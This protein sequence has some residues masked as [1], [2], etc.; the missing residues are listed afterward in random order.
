MSILEKILI[1]GLIVAILIATYYVFFSIKKKKKEKSDSKEKDKKIKKSK[2]SKDEIKESPLVE[3][4]VEKVFKS[5][6]DKEEEKPT[7][8][9]SQEQEMVLEKQPEKKAEPFKII[10]KKSEVKI[11]KKAIKADSRNPSITKVF[12]KNGKKLELDENELEKKDEFSPD[13]LSQIESM[14]NDGVMSG[15][16]G[17]NPER[18]GYREPHIKERN[19]GGEYKIEAPIGSPNRA[20]IIRDRTNF[21]SH[22]NISEDGNLSGVVGT[23][24]AKIIDRAERQSEEIDKK[25]DDMIRNIRM[26]LLNERREVTGG[27][28]FSYGQEDFPR[29][30]VRTSPIKK[31]KNIDAKTLIIAEAISNPKYKGDKR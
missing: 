13:E 30:S 2:K 22:L 12:D 21:G 26:N 7:D 20:P 6:K 28:G 9:P 15:I 27:Y 29:P 18:F 23:G 25:T 8:K 11:H 5:D 1:Y 19:V 16:T 24:V 14:E 17:G 4:K 31:A 10:R 3:K